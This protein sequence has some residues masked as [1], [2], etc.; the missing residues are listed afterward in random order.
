MT[1]IRAVLAAA[2]L[3]LLLAAC[4]P[5]EE[6][7]ATTRLLGAS[8][9]EQACWDRIITRES[10]GDPTATG[11]AG[12][13]GLVQIHPIHRSWLGG[14]WDRM[15]EPAANAFAAVSLKA[16]AGGWSPWRGCPDG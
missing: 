2:V 4:T 12:E 10:G 14:W 15:Y 1:K 7:L 3:L 11:S 9:Q 5:R 8:P 13:R 6:F 16:Q